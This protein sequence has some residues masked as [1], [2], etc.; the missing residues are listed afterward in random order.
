MAIHLA[1]RTLDAIARALVADKGNAYRA[2]LAEVLPHIGDAYREDDDPYRSHLGASVIGGPC[3]RALWYGFR[4]AHQSTPTGKAKEDDTHGHARM[5]R[6]WNRGHLEEGR[7]IALLL[8][9]GVQVYQQDANGHQYRVSFFGGHYGGSGDGILLGVPDL[10][11]G[12]PCGGEFKTHSDDTF[13]KLLSDGVQASKPEHYAQIQTY[14]RGFGLQYFLY[15]AVNKNTDELYG[16]IVCY[17]GVTDELYMRRARSLIFDNATPAR[18]RL[19]S[20]TH[21]KCKHGCGVKAVCWGAVAPDRNCRTCATVR[22]REDGTVRCGFTELF[23]AS[24]HESLTKEQ[25]R[26]GCDRYQL[27]P[28]FKD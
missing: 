23:P 26:A 19:A 8:M 7:F 5:I 28:L 2:R 11:P 3:D 18:M 20:P 4:W 17:D 10:P 12:V 16:E 14:M 9:I 21:W 22:F 27:S 1:T 13:K 24:A 25:Q 15:L 6:L